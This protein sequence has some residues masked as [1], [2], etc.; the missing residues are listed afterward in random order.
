[1]PGMIPTLL[2]LIYLLCA[3]L[4]ALYA[5][6]Q[7]ILLIVYLKIRRRTP[8]LPEIDAW[9]T[10]TVQLPVYNERYVVRR[11]L[12]AAAA[13][14]YP[15]EK[16]TIQVLD[17][18]T[19]DTTRIVSAQVRLLRREGLNIWHVRRPQR[20]G[21]K[22]GALAHGLSQSQSELVAIFDADFIPPADFLR[23]TVP[24]F[25]ADERLGIVQTRWGHLNPFDNLLTLA[26]TL[27]IDNH[28]LI[29]Q[30]ARSRSG[31]TLSF[32]GT[33][34]L[35]RAECIAAAGGWSDT[36]LTEDLDLSYRAQLAG[37]RYLMLPDIVVPGEVPPQI[38][39]Y[40]QQQSRWARGSTQCLIRLM[41][42]VW[43]GRLSIMARLMALHNLGQYLPHPLMFL[44]LLLTPPLIL[45][46]MM[47]QIPLAPLGIIGVIPPLS[48]AISQWSLY[49]DWKR[50]MLAFPVM[51]LLGAGIT[52]NNTWAVCS[53]LT[54]RQVGF[55]RTPKFGGG[56]PQSRY[57]LQ[58][59]FGPLVEL[60]LMAY[61]LW[62]AWLAAKMHPALLPY[63]LLYAAGFG[64]MALWGLRDQWQIRRAAQMPRS[65]RIVRAK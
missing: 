59:D 3:I 55:V 34:G 12:E 51:M 32:N 23:R 4:L 5:T 61:A 22:A 50:R 60:A 48:V 36:T 64:G 39:A 47:S 42:P 20:T 6:G 8:P 7:L 38:A 29:E 13:L 46:G 45:A 16:L 21:Y 57:A 53:A 35:W 15:R 1:M 30:N 65:R 25:C 31:W 44:L 62:G 17:D 33:G 9:P 37:W 41:G 52:W 49:R 18:S 43:R 2:A 28:F 14:D 56:W 40:K 19:D 54:R 26:Q 11:L 24:H 10:V 63:L 58:K 27:S